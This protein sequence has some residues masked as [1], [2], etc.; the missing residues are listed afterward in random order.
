[1]NRSNETRL[2]K[3]ENERAGDTT[4]ALIVVDPMKLTRMPRRAI[5]GAADRAKRC[6]RNLCPYG[7]STL[8]TL[9]V[10][11]TRTAGLCSPLSFLASHWPTHE[12]CCR[13]SLEN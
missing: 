12:G 3:L 2:R 8:E 10:C 7:R 6:P 5:S 9:V 11:R 1:M 4:V 13:K